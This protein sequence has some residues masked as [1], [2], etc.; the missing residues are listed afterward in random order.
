MVDRDVFRSSPYLRNEPLEGYRPQLLISPHPRAPRFSRAD[1]PKV[2]EELVRELGSPTAASSKEALGLFREAAYVNL[3]IFLKFIAGYSGPYNKLSWQLHVDLCN[4][5]QALLEPGTKGAAFVPRSSFK[6]TVMTHGAS[7][8][9]LLRNPDLRIG[10][11]SSKF[12]RAA[13]FMHTTQRVFDDNGLFEGLFPEYA[14]EGG[15]GSRWNDTEA[16][17]PCRS[18][19]YPEPNL[20]AHSAGGST[21]GVH[22]DLA[23]FDDIIDD[24]QLNSDHGATADLYR[25]K[26]W[27]FTNMRTLLVGQESRVVLSATR[28]AL[29]D[30]YE[31]IMKD[32]F[33]HVGYWGDSD[34]EYPVRSDGEWVVYYRRALENG[35]SIFPEA[36]TAE[37]LDKIAARDPW[38]YQTQYLNDPRST[39]MLEF[40]SMKPKVCTLDYSVE[41]GEF[42]IERPYQ[43]TPIPLSGCDLIFACDPAA[44]EKR[45]SQRTSQTAI[46]VLAT[47]WEDNCYFL[48][49]T[50]GY[51]A[52]SVYIDRLFQLRDRYKGA[53]RATFVEM[54]AGF[55]VLGDIIREEEKRRGLYLNVRPV[56]ALVHKEDT[57][58]SIWE[59]LLKL[60]KVYTNS[61][62]CVPLEAEVALFPSVVA[63]DL[64]DAGKIAL[65]AR[66]EGTKPEYWEEDPELAELRRLRHLS[67]RGLRADPVSGY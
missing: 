31:D 21:A 39:G 26:N 56:N 22:V 33:A 2:L 35:A 42:F 44:S 29:D 63:K 61:E 20:K 58:R 15:Y 51:W 55:K 6:S 3:F 45:M 36:Y 38:T 4:F 16:V 18:R 13:E 10:I 57:I 12:E 7:A 8:W 62:A 25:M 34:K 32:A 23:L 41:K 59:P 40:V 47:D 43:K 27:L 30:P 52:P 9:E 65:H 24:S 50:K 64:L 60:G 46:V 14:P 48:E 67:L 54:Q 1:G 19:N 28:Y 11:F 37:S 49:A 66:V 5:R 17:L 53:Q